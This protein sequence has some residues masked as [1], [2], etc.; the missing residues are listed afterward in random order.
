MS[1][2]RLVRRMI[3]KA[4]RAQVVPIGHVALAF[5]WEHLRRFFAHFAIDCVFDIGANAGQYATML[6]T[7]VGYRGP[8]ISYEPIPELATKIRAAA[9]LDRGWF[10]EELALDAVEGQATFNVF[11][12]DVFSSLHAASAVAEQQ[13]PKHLRLERRIEVRT[14]TLANELARY[15]ARLGFKRPFL[16]M[17]TQGHDVSVAVGAGDRLRDFVGLQSELA[18]GRLYMDAPDYAEALE[19]YRGRGFE[20]SALVPNN[21]GHFPRLLEID[22]I[23]FRAPPLTPEEFKQR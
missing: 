12:S 13:F 14:G 5:E 7:R 17:D 4:L 22:C 19:F 8:I 6:R 2:R 16:K 11:A 9:A 10:V 1:V 15:Q 21:L 23:M 18:I 20:L 3:E